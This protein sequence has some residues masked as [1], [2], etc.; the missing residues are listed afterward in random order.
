MLTNAVPLPTFANHETFH[1]RHAWLKKAYDA[2]AKD[3]GVFGRQD[4]TI[5]LGT[6]KNMVKSMRFWSVSCKV[7]RPSGDRKDPALQ[8]TPVGRAIFRNRG[9]LDPYTEHPQT[10]WLLHWLLLAPPCR[11]PVWWIIM[12]ELSGTNVR[13]DD[14]TEFVS[15]RVLNTAAWKT[16]SPKSLKKDIDVFLHTYSTY[17]GK[18]SMEDYI[19][20]P[21]RGLHLVRQAERDTIRFVYGPKHGLTPLVVAYACLDYASRL[22]LSAKS[23]SVSR[24]ATEAGGAGQAFKLGERELAGLLDEAASKSD[25]IRIRNVNG[26]N[27]MVYGDAGEAA[28]AVLGQA[29]GKKGFVMPKGT[30]Q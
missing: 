17:Q 1:L 28:G 12:N 5:T 6:G 16:P 2:V 7:L 20:C 14:M 4:A 8:A 15:Q 27:H 22:E 29:Y 25:A 13:V 26:S 21:F 11:M 19:D 10:M 9:G 24:L 30:V 3:P 23:I 18:L